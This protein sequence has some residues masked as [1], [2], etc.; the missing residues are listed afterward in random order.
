MVDAVLSYFGVS[1]LGDITQEMLD[2][3]RIG[4]LPA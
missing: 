4:E 3:A 1:R 2:A